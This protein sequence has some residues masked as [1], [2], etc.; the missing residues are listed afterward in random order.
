MITDD[1]CRLPGDPPTDSEDFDMNAVNRG[2]AVFFMVFA[3]LMG[4]YIWA[5]LQTV[6]QY[7]VVCY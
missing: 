1:G 4:H 7:I 5:C 3:L 2:N 6:T